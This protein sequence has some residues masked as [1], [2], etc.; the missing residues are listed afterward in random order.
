MKIPRRYIPKT[1][2]NRDSGKQRSNLNKSRR[3]YKR[4]I[5]VSRPKLK[6]FHSR[7]SSHIKNAKS[8]YGVKTV[9]VGSLSKKS[10]CSQSALRKIL[11]KGRGAYYSSGSRPNQTAESWARARLASSLTGGPASKVDYSILK[12][13]C[14]PGSSALRAARSTR[15]NRK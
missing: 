11:S 1:L 7:K 12:N 2:S 14:K 8:K 10:G 4:G 13:G 9:S 5:Y 6:S 3:L 15:K